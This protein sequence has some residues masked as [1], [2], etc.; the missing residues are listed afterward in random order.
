MFECLFRLNLYFCYL[1][2]QSYRMSEDALESFGDINPISAMFLWL[3]FYFVGKLTAARRCSAASYELA[4]VLR[5]QALEDQRK[6]GSYNLAG[7]PGQTF[8]CRLLPNCLHL[9]SLAIITAG[10]LFPFKV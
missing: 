2:L 6:Q 5:L 8:C 10:L 4:G 9:L 3:F 7:E 1:A